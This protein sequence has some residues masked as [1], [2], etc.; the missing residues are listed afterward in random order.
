MFP[1]KSPFEYR[2][3]IRGDLNERNQKYTMTLL[4]ETTRQFATFRYDLAIRETREGN[5]IKFVV[6]GLKAPQLSLPANGPAQ[7]SRQY[8][9]LEGTYELVIEGLDHR[10]DTFKVRFRKNAATVLERPAHPFVEVLTGSSH[11]PQ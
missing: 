6:T 3:S 2:L 7:F 8:E 10:V 4:M 11:H 1:E 5:H 9:S